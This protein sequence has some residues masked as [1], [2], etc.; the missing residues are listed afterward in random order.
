[1]IERYRNIFNHSF[2]EGKYEKFI[3][4]LEKGLIKIPFRLAETPVFIP[5]ELKEQ[6]I[7]AG[8][9][10]ISMIKQPDF[11]TLTQGAIPAEWNVP[12]RK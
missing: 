8:E 7:A 12:A 11:K 9:E 5:E 10:I 1:M 2:S 4:S 3:A 6:L